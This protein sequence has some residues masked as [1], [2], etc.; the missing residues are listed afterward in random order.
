M[1]EYWTILALHKY[2]TVK[3][4]SK[5]L[6]YLSRLWAL[7]LQP[8]SPMF[9]W[10]APLNFDTPVASNELKNSYY[11][12]ISKIWS[13]KTRYEYWRCSSENRL[14]LSVGLMRFG[15]PG[16]KLLS[17]NAAPWSWSGRLLTQLLLGPL[18]DAVMSP[19]RAHRPG[20]HVPRVGGGV[21]A[22]FEGFPRIL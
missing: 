19:A 15:W 8:S 5:E 22:P 13:Q 18:N 14:S 7:L 1:K 20:R 12:N 16:I 17:I 3:S 9:E 21:N 11:F 6:I 2:L 10:R 4:S